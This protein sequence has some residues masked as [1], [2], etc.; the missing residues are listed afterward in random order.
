MKYKDFEEAFSLER[1][2]KYLSACNRI[3]KACC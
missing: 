1:M 3:T 2:G